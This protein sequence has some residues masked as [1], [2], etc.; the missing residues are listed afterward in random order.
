MDSSYDFFIQKIDDSNIINLNSKIFKYNNN[1]V[2]LLTADK[3]YILNFELNHLIKL[4]N[5]FL[6]AKIIFKNELGKEYILDNKNKI[7]ENLTGKNIN[8]ISNKNALIYFY[9]KINSNF[10][11]ISPIEFD[12]TKNGKYMKL[13][14]TNKKLIDETILISKDFC[15]KEYYPMI[16]S[17]NLQKIVIKSKSTKTVY[18]ENYYDKFEFNNLYEKEGEKFYIYLFELNKNNKLTLL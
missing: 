10:S 15:F 7:I 3:K 2:K 11:Q 14:I 17:K 5:N 18:I 6:D 16:N 12:K 1:L 4:D 13:I 8:I 9:E